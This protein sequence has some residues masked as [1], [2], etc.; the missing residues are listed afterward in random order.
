[1]NQGTDITADKKKLPQLL[2]G[3]AA[4]VLLGPLFAFIIGDLDAPNYLLELMTI[5]LIEVPFVVAFAFLAKKIDWRY[6]FFIALAGSVLAGAV[7]WPSVT[8]ITPVIFLKVALT[9]ILIGIPRF[10]KMQFS[11]H[12]TVAMV[13]GLVLG[14]VLGGV[15]VLGGVAPDVLEQTKQE[16]LEVYQA[17]MTEDEALNAVENAMYFFKSIF[18]VAMA[19]YVFFAVVLTWLSFYFAKVIFPKFGEQPET[20]PPLYMFRTPFHAVWFFLAGGALW[21]IG[22]EPAVPLAINLMASMAGLYGLQGMA[23]VTYYVNGLSMGHLPKVLFWLIFFLTI[24]FSGV[25]LIITGILDNWFNMRSIPD[26]PGGEEGQNNEDY[27]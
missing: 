14:C 5:V 25:F 10:A 18:S 22:Y 23:I 15:I 9:G 20:V 6:A 1:M 7:L 13:P 17:F 19:F 3:I 11:R 12:M 16:T 24:G 26:N 4:C 27:S 21:V 8:S 2:A